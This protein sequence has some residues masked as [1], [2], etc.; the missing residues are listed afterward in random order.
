RGR[1][2]GDLRA[3]LWRGA[4]S[5]DGSGPRI[6][7]WPPPDVRGPLR[8]SRLDVQDEAHAFRGHARAP[9]RR[10]TSIGP[11]RAR[12][13]SSPA[14]SGAPH[15]PA[16]TRRAASSPAYAPR[17]TIAA[18]ASSVEPARKSPRIVGTV[19]PWRRIGAH[20]QLI[21]CGAATYW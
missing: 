10:W 8:L 5:A 16:S 18:G 14:G 4:G 9:R 3:G 19:S 12:S 15:P 2:D 21:V 1:L 13:S 7:G 6:R 17:S 20:A 11:L